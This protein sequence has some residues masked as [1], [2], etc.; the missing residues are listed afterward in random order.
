MTA[1]S[2]TLEYFLF[3]PFLPQFGKDHWACVYSL[4][5]AQSCPAEGKKHLAE[6]EVSNFPQSCE[7]QCLSRG[8]EGGGQKGPPSS[9]K[10]Q[11]QIFS[12]SVFPQSRSSP[13]LKSRY[14][15]CKYFPHV[16]WSAI[17]R[18]VWDHLSQ[19]TILQEWCGY[20]ESLIMSSK[21]LYCHPDFVPSVIYA[22]FVFIF[23]EILAI[24]IKNNLFTDLFN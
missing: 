19:W 15:H 8:R 17:T 12:N 20:C 11:G 6:A 2:W 24:V 1:I 10:R 4:Y 13:S 22:N 7:R 3:L 5:F 9:A 14:S 21:L 16:Q 18:P 23:D